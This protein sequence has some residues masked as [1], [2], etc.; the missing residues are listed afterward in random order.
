VGTPAAAPAAGLSFAGKQPM[1]TISAPKALTITNTGNVPLQI[2]SLTFGGADPQDFLLASDGCVGQVAVGS[3]CTLGVSF[4]PQR[5]GPRSATL[6]IIANSPAAVDVP[7]S[8]TGG[9][10]PQGPPGATGPRGPAGAIELVMC[11]TVTSKRVV[12]KGAKRHTVHVRRQQC[13]A[14]LVSGKITFMTTAAGAR[15]TVS[16]GRVVYATGVAV[17]T[18]AGRLQLLL[19]DVRRIRRGGYEL[20]LRTSHGRRSTTRRIAITVT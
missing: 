9:P 6:E 12:G 7:L 19:Q 17:A 1:Q 2:S 20:T 3:Q 11:N 18:G 4:A 10:L 5:Q 16:R 8:G 13:T 14:R 15:A